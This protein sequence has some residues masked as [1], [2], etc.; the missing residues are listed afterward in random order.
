MPRRGENIYKRKDGRWEGRYIES[1]SLNGKAKYRSVYANTYNEVRFRMKKANIDKRLSPIS[2]SA[3]DWIENYIISLKDKIKPSTY[4]VYMRYHR[5]H[6]KPFFNTIRLCKL[7]TEF[8]QVF[9]DSKSY[10][11][12]STLKGIFT[13]LKQALK[14]AYDKNYIDDIWSCAE[15]PKNRKNNVK[16]FTREEQTLIENAVNIDKNP[17]EIGILIGL[18]TGLR[19]GEI[20]GLKWEDINFV[21]S[22]LSVRRTVQRITIDNKSIVTE[23]PPKSESSRRTIPMPSFLCKILRNIYGN[24]DDYII[25][26]YSH[27]MD[28]R[29]MQNQYQRLLKRAG[30][31][32][33]NFHTIR[34]TFSVRA[35]ENGFDIKTLSEILGHADVSVTLKRYAHS[36]DEHK[37]KSM[38]RLN[39][40]YSGNLP[41]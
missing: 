27:I 12:P 10:L 11:A 30:V 34:H 21:S 35:L 5:N 28:P 40:I 36:L 37:R 29:T 15:L 24:S 7:S 26:L 14:I 25:K 17:N 32:Y 8:L 4:N 18:Y 2:I 16:V 9:I 6:I 23:F 39:C 20:C 38:E 22:T 3:S 41:S 19:L 33:A 13:I 31:E 1:Y